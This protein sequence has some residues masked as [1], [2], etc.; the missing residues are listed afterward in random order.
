MEFGFFVDGSNQVGLGHFK[1]SLRLALKMKNMGF[2]IFWF[3]DLL[4]S[5]EDEIKRN[6]IKYKFLEIGDYEKIL[7][8]IKKFSLKGVVID[9]YKVRSQDLKVIQN[10]NP[11]LC[12]VYINDYPSMKYYCDIL[13]DHNIFPNNVM[14]KYTSLC[15]KDC[16]LLLGSEYSFIGEKSDFS[17]PK[18]FTNLDSN[19]RKILICFGGSENQTSLT[20]KYLN[21]L[22]SPT[23]IICGILPGKKKNYKL[24]KKNKI[25]LGYQD[26]LDPFYEW[27][28]VI[29]GGG[30]I[31]IQERLAH[32][33]PSF[34][35]ILSKDQEVSSRYVSSEGGIFLL[36]ENL[37]LSEI[38]LS[39]D[40]VL[41]SK[42]K[43]RLKGNLKVSREGVSKIA[44]KIKE[45]YV[46]K[47]LI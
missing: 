4:S 43:F 23:R 38:N 17:L 3:G 25:L 14:K 21:I 9:S 46:S 10:N 12:L 18:F 37:S 35:K 28:D 45:K 5:V 30:G 19:K 8:A 44:E 20:K 34:V 26:S 29:F 41:S 6:D 15:S 42:D 16:D 7:I 39:L 1:R 36:D 27:A 2:N 13:I 32:E 24:I 40:N 11:Q 22:D 33:K 31:S 47:N